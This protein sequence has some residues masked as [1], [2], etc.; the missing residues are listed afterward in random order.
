MRRTT[1]R[2][3]VR[4]AGAL[5][6]EALAAALGDVVGRHETLR[7]VFPAVDG[8]PYQRVVPVR[9]VPIAVV[10]GCAGE[11]AGLRRWAERGVWLCV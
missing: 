9:A 5:D 7:T 4:L 2:W 6:R 3:R 11:E 8:E 1:F 10:H